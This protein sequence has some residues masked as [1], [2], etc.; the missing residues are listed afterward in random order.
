MQL[1]NSRKCVDGWMSGLGVDKWVCL[2]L[3]PHLSPLHSITVHH[4]YTH[5]IHKANGS[6]SPTD[7]F[8]AGW[9]K[10]TETSHRYENMQRSSD[11]ALGFY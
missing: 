10:P 3:T 7:M 5:Y 4:I 9:R 1:H 11:P 6:N 2:L 8:L